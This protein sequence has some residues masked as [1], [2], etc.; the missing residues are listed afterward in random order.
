MN[1]IDMVPPEIEKNEALE[2][3]KP[4]AVTE[5]HRFLGL[6]RWFRAFIPKY[7]EITAELMRALKRGKKESIEW[8]KARNEAYINLKIALKK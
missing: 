8:T 7:A 1:G 5:L 6:M 2:Y 3:A 4:R